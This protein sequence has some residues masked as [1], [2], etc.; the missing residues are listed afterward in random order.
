MYACLY[1][2]HCTAITGIHS[3]TTD[4]EKSGNRRNSTASQLF[5]MAR[6]TFEWTT[7]LGTDHFPGAGWSW[8]TTCCKE[9][10]TQSRRRKTHRHCFF[11]FLF[12]P[13]KP[14]EG[15]RTISILPTLIRACEALRVDA[16]HVWMQQHQT[17]YDWACRG[18]LAAAAVGGPLLEHLTAVGSGRPNDAV[19]LTMLVDVV[20]CFETL[21]LLQVRYWAT[22]AGLPRKS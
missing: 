6:A 8:T 18:T 22:R 7:G 21:T 20:K 2:T 3:S 9:Q 16:F 1:R 19:S 15:F 13:P 17:K 11:L 14:A 5:W 12:F 4:S 10:K